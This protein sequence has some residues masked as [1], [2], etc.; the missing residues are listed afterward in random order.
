MRKAGNLPTELGRLTLDSDP[1]PETRLE[2]IFNGR[3]GYELG[4]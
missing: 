1:A 3:L 2:R 4:T